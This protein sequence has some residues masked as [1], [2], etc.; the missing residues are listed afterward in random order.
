MGKNQFHPRNSGAEEPCLRTLPLKDTWYAGQEFLR[1]AESSVKKQTKTLSG[2]TF[3]FLRVYL[4][5]MIF[6][7]NALF[8]LPTVLG[9]FWPIL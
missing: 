7:K 4:V 3:T 9:V 2:L 1:S 5:Y 8:Y 6:L